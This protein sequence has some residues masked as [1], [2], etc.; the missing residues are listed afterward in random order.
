MKPLIVVLSPRELP[1]FL[2]AVKTIDHIDKFW[3][4]NHVKEEAYPLMMNEFLNSPSNYTHLI[5]LPD[6]LVVTKSDV[7]ELIH[8][9]LTYFKDLDYRNEKVLACGFCNVDVLE[10]KKHAAVSFNTVSPIREGRQYNFTTLRQIRQKRKQ[11]NFVEVGWAGFPLMIISR[12][13]IEKVGRFRND[14]PSGEEETGCCYDVMFC[15]DAHQKGCKIF[16][17]TKVE[18]YHLKH[19]HKAIT[20]QDLKYKK[21]ETY[22]EYATTELNPPPLAAP[23]ILENS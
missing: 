15:H 7:D 23:A 6:D 21:K 5:P 11:S 13:I 22:W 2:D 14:S 9:Y 20:R 12:Q 8:D 1:K 17:D 19:Q 10:N 3:I 4:R 18:M 16:C